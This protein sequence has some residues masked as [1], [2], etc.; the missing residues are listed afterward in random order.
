M[1]HDWF[2]ILDIYDHDNHLD[3]EC[4]KVQQPNFRLL[5]K[6]KAITKNNDYICLYMCKLCNRENIIALNTFVKKVK[7]GI[8]GCSTCK[9]VGKDNGTLLEKLIRDE[10]EYDMM[11]EEYKRMY[12]R[13]YLTKDEYQRISS[14]IISFQ[15]DKFVYLSALLL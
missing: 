2:V 5:Y 3:M 12:F 15:H 8:R 6:N 11:D 9:V 13:K 1:E 10:L 14:T 7:K 4:V